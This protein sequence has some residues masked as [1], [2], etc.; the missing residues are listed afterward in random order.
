MAT[1]YR[2]FYVT[3]WQVLPGRNVEARAWFDKAAA[4]WQRLPGVRSM[5]AFVGQFELS[6]TTRTIEVWAEIEDYGVLDRW[7]DAMEELGDEVIALGKKGAA[8]VVQG[9]S[10]LVGD[11]VGSGVLDLKIH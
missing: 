4:L 3:T 7:D 8:C 6:P 11:Y 5:N 9:P 1:R 2:L 10:R